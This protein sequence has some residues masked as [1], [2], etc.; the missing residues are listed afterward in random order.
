MPIGHSFSWFN[1]PDEGR[2]AD[3]PPD[4]RCKYCN[5]RY[6][7]MESDIHHCPVMIERQRQELMGGER[8]SQ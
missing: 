7:S 3:P 8:R 6:D 5:V 4:C 1:R 2:Y